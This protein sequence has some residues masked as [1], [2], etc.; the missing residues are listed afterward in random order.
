MCGLVTI[1]GK[2]GNNARDRLNFTMTRVATRGSIRET[3]SLRVHFSFYHTYGLIVYFIVKRKNFGTSLRFIILAT[4][5]S[6]GYFALNV[7]FGGLVYG[8]LAKFFGSLL[9]LYPITST[10]N[11][12]T[13]QE[14][15]L[16][17]IL[18][19]R[20]GL[21][22]K[23]VRGIATLVRGLWVIALGPQCLG[24]CYSRVLASSITLIGGVITGI[25]INGTVSF[26]FLVNFG[27]NLFL[28][29]YHG[30]LSITSCGNFG[31]KV[32][33]TARGVTH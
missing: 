31:G 29:T 8:V 6:F 11:V 18:M 14:T 10:R 17:C 2:F 9:Y 24:L 19:G 22:Y 5:C 32:F 15:F 1:R 30:G 25:G 20:A 13:C 12:G 26:V 27:T 16:T 23:C 7:G 4:F 33:G 3:M 21:I 28:F